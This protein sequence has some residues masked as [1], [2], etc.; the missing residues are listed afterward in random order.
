MISPG[1]ALDQPKRPRPVT[2]GRFLRHA[3][4][5]PPELA[6][7]WARGQ[8]REGA[9]VHLDNP[10]RFPCACVPWRLGVRCL[11]FHTLEAGNVKK[12]TSTCKQGRER[13]KKM[14]GNDVR[15]GNVIEN[16]G[17]NNILSCYHSDILGNSEP[18]FTE[19]SRFGTTKC[20]FSMLSH[21][22]CKG[23]TMPRFEPPAL[24]GARRTSPPSSHSQY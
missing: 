7:R 4:K 13:G 12:S 23:S 1:N 2:G 20:T 9:K 14:L 10:F 15:N 24:P 16:K 11:P 22:K 5:V 17:S 8:R 18:V 19:N 3:R 6:E 21:R